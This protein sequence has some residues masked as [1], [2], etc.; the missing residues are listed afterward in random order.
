[1]GTA[2]LLACSPIHGAYGSH[3]LRAGQRLTDGHDA[4]GCD[5]DA[6]LTDSLDWPGWTR[7]C[8]DDRMGLDFCACVPHSLPRPKRI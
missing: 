7:R 3:V 5:A 1:M 4:V 8:A 2:T 6:R